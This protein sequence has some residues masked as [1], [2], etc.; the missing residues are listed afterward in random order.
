MRKI[1]FI[2][3][4]LSAVIVA[5]AQVPRAQ[6]TVSARQPRAEDRRENTS[7]TLQPFEFQA[8]FRDADADFNRLDLFTNAENS[9]KSKGRTQNVFVHVTRKDTGAPVPFVLMDSDRSGGNDFKTLDLEIVV[10]FPPPERAA[11]IA[12]ALKALK[13]SPFLKLFNEPGGP[14]PEQFFD[15]YE[16]RESQPGDYVIKVEY[17]ASSGKVSSKPLPFTI[18]DKGNL[19]E[20]VIRDMAPGR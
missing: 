14:T 3:F 5:F 18:R 20:K 2:V 8:E 10:P 1:F 17:H 19:Y 13:D 4:L 6:V 7:S 11:R 9:H 12:A 16:V 15:G